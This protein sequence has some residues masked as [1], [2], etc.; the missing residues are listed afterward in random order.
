MKPL[1]VLAASMLLWLPMPGSGRAASD[2]MAREGK[3][4]NAT[5]IITAFERGDAATKVVVRLTEPQPMEEAEE[6]TSAGARAVLH[7]AIARVQAD[8]LLALE[9]SHVQLRHRFE[10]QPTFS[11]EVTPEGL[12]QLLN[13]PRVESIEPVY[14]L[15]KFT[16]QGIPLINGMAYRST[17]NGQGVG[18]AIIDD[19]IDYTHPRLGG[20]A[21]PNGKVVDGYDLGQGDSD[22]FP[23]QGRAREYHGTGCAGI[24]AGDVDTVGDYIGG[25]ASGA[26]LYAL[27]VS[28]VDPDYGIVIWSDTAANA[29]DWCVTHK[30]D[31][32]AYPILVINLSIGHG[33][34]DSPCDN[35]FDPYT[36]AVNSAV[37]A[38]IT[39]VAAAGNGGFC[40]ATARPACVA[41]AISVGAVYDSNIGMYPPQG[42]VGC[43]EA[44]SCVGFPCVE[45]LSGRCFSDPVTAADQ[46]MTLSNS[47]PFLDLFAPGSQGHT[48]DVTGYEGY[49]SELN[50][51][52]RCTSLEFNPDFSATSAAAAYA[53]GAVACLQSASKARSGR[54]L[55]PSEVR[56]LLTSNGDMVTDTKASITKPRINL[57]RA[58]EQIPQSGGGGQTVTIGSGTHE[59]NYPIRTNWH[60]SRTQIIYLAAELGGGDPITSLAI[61]VAQPPAQTLNNW[62]IRMKHVSADTFSVCSL[63]ST[64]WTTVYQNNEVISNAGWRQFEFQ[65]PFAYNGTDNLMVDFSH[66][67]SSY[68]GDGK[69]RASEPGGLRSA[70][71]YSDSR[72][73]DPLD[74]S[75]TVIDGRS[76]SCSDLVPNVRLTFDRTQVIKLTPPDGA[77]G[78]RFGSSVS[79]SGDYVVAGAWAD[80]DRGS[81]SGSAHVFKRNGQNWVRQAKL[82]ASDGEAGDGFSS[83]DGVA[84]SGDTV[85]VG[86]WSVDDKGCAYIF[87]RNGTTWTQQAKL[88]A[89][90]RAVGDEFG[91]TVGI[92]GDYAIVG[93]RGDDD[94][95][96]SA[97]AAYVFKRTG[98]TWQQQAK[99]V[100]TDGAAGDSAGNSVAISS[101]YA[102]VGAYGDD[103][104]GSSA[105]AAYIFARNGSSWF[106]Q[107]KLRASDGAASAFFGGAVSISADYAAVGASKDSSSAQNA[108]AVYIF[109]RS[110]S[111]WTQ[112]AKLT[113]SDAI[114]GASFGGTVSIRGNH[115]VA[116]AWSDASKGSNAGAAYLFTRVQNSWVEQARLEPGGL[117]TDDHF[118]IRVSIDDDYVII[119]ANG[120]DD[121]GSNS[122]AAYIFSLE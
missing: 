4:I 116:G 76:V 57:G 117:D 86:T 79:A 78:D 37:S 122:G 45:C 36:A 88:M 28:E 114:A 22:P 61:D 67:N 95:G 54:F 89:S 101:D 69:C 71:V 107:T 59:W 84:I 65:T 87:K 34:F 32:P 8:V 52:G 108:G 30:N 26:K 90:D 115:V 58:I 5:K 62:T 118:G 97:G 16:K 11:A 85:I 41:N 49:C 2:Q 72:A 104:K 10:N 7:R 25:V 21:F 47:A 17:Y 55:S 23:L 82:T 24:A 100:P 74:W 120:D 53:S 19:G 91:T 3:L 43:I 39:V 42:W 75:G 18:I 94:K 73:G 51:Y 70:Y 68:K 13:D 102:I 110:T 99:L 96:S 111:A 6:S 14:M 66:N 35:I 29:I 63:D 98:N 50:D 103:D 105:G 60:D 83:G 1:T 109:R 113:A 81:D 64:G 27:K 77:G 106:Q 80:D 93:A 48:T 20:G 31:H 15:E 9:P 40:S 33:Q 121:K 56:S 46:V 38:G 44:D 92:S 12:A 112:Q 119:G